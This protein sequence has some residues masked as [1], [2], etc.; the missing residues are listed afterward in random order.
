MEAT[1]MLKGAGADPRARWQAAIQGVIA[2]YL[3]ESVAQRKAKQFMRLRARLGDAVVNCFNELES[4]LIE[5]S[6]LQ[7]LLNSDGGGS[8]H[9]W[10][11]ALYRAICY[12]VFRGR[13]QPNDM[14]P[15]DI[16]LV[17]LIRMTINYL[18]PLDN[19]GERGSRPKPVL[20]KLKE[21]SSGDCLNLNEEALEACMSDV[22]DLRELIERLGRM[23]EFMP[24]SPTPF[25]VQ[26]PPNAPFHGSFQ[27]QAPGGQ[28]MTVACPP[29]VVAGQ[30]LQLT[31]PAP[32]RAFDNTG[33]YKHIE[34]AKR[35]T[36]IAKQKLEVLHVSRRKSKTGPSLGLTHDRPVD[37]IELLKVCR[38]N[39]GS[40]WA[41]GGLEGAL[42]L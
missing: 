6:T 25:Q 37:C 29:G 28:I 36:S 10:C 21:I 4:A 3:S 19:Q 18:G 41:A 38:K 9:K 26:V 16:S 27:V 39:L 30:M 32:P 8:V 34:D 35:W 15:G 5:D 7:T 33:G 42:K 12:A 13:I 23:P 11:K 17:R 20:E 31:A 14:I 24:A 2:V 22:S 1:E 40:E